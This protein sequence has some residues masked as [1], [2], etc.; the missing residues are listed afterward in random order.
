M[1]PDR[2][3]AGY[4]LAKLYSETGQTGKLLPIACYLLEK[5]PKIPSSAVYD[6]KADMNL[7]LKQYQE[8]N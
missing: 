1:L 2:F 4:L 7:I 5:D 3:Y 8:T 6:I